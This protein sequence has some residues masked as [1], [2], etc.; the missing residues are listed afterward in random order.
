MNVG[1][2]LAAGASTRMGRPKALEPLRGQSFLARGVRA[3]WA[4]CDS[5]VVVLGS[6]AGRIQSAVEEEFATLMERG[7]LAPEMQAAHGHGSRGLEVH[8]AVNVRWRRGMASSARAGLAEALRLKPDAVLILPVDHPEVRASSVVAMSDVMAQAVKAFGGGKG[9]SIR[10]ASAKF[11][12][13]LV[14]RYNGRR[15]HPVAV[16]SA[17]ARMITRDGAAESLSDAIKR[18]ARLIGY[19]DV[20]DP[21]IV[22]N[23][24]TP[25]P[26]GRAKR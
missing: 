2:L 8:F 3:L 23:R 21:G 6:D 16:T 1:V 26:R 4:A 17:L 15:G 22:K 11:A 18:N 5:V 12:Y 10:A 14:P 24:N 13:A 25:A 7:V 20:A 9:R 19:L